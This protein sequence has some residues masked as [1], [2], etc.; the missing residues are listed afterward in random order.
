MGGKA[1]PLPS[2]SKD[3]GPWFENVSTL[4]TTCRPQRRR[5]APRAPCG[6]SVEGAL[7]LRPGPPPPPSTILAQALLSGASV[8]SSLGPGLA[9]GR[10]SVSPQSGEEWTEGDSPH[11]PPKRGSGWLGLIRAGSDHNPVFSAPCSRPGTPSLP[12]P[13]SPGP[14]VLVS[15]LGA[16]QCPGGAG[17]GG[18]EGRAPCPPCPTGQDLRW[19]PPPWTLEGLVG[20]GWRSPSTSPQG[21]LPQGAHVCTRVCRGAPALSRKGRAGRG[22][23]RGLQVGLPPMPAPAKLPQEN[24]TRI[25]ETALPRS[26]KCF[27]WF[28]L[29]EYITQHFRATRKAVLRLSSPSKLVPMS[30]PLPGG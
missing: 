7:R 16:G 10:L 27:M 8:L 14:V 11:P 2:G 26:S 17:D 5:L 29:V 15:P 13:C 20:G 3:P 28:Q 30:G 9:E 19:S 21:F 4:L 24:P 18:H 12:C 23:A 6:P 25:P 1:G 22:G